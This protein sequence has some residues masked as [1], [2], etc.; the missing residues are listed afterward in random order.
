MSSLSQDGRAGNVI[1]KDLRVAN[2]EFELS[3]ESTRM[4]YGSREYALA[5]STM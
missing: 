4:I 3:N 5:N 2:V 1:C